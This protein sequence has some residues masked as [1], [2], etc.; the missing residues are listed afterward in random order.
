MVKLKHS[1]KGYL[2][3]FTRYFREWEDEKMKIALTKPELI[4]LE[5]LIKHIKRN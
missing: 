3:T 2:V 5:K 4:A 1:K